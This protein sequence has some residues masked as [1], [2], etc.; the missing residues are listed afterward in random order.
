MPARKSARPAPPI[1]VGIGGHVVALRRDDGEIAW[2]VKLRRGG[3]LVSL[4][5]AGPRLFAVSGGE[6][7]CLDAT[8]GKILWHNPLKGFGVGYAMLAGGLD[9]VAAAALEAAAAT[10]ATTTAATT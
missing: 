10:A 9:P 2:S 1:H 7:S 6:L 5:L 4:L 8:T 3:S